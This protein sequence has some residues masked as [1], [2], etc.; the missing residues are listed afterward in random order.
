VVVG[1]EQNDVG[2]ARGAFEEGPRCASENG[3][4]S[5]ALHDGVIVYRDNDVV[6]K[7]TLLERYQAAVQ[8]GKFS[9]P[10]S[11]LIGFRLTEV[12]PGYA[13]V[14]LECTQ[15]HYNPTGSLH[16]GVLCAIADTAMGIAHA[17][18]LNEGESSTTTELKINFLRPVRQGKLR[19]MGRV[20]KHGKTLTVIESDVVDEEGQL[21]ARALST[22]MTLRSQ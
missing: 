2:V 4:A 8:Q 20:I 11:E 19:A 7:R 21:V 15:Q 6:T 16:G 9:F 10:L 22:C 5:D 18:L 12:E 3:A 14:D 13:A 1:H 17:S